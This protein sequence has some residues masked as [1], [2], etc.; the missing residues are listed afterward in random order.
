MSNFLSLAAWI[1]A[2]AALFGIATIGLVKSIERWKGVRFARGD[3]W[4]VALV[5]SCLAFLIVGSLGN[6]PGRSAAFK[7]FGIVAGSTFLTLFM[8]QLGKFYSMIDHAF[9]GFVDMLGR[10]KKK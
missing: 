7:A 5:I 9:D 6:H 1:V 10:L 2:F 8:V 3:Y 4:S